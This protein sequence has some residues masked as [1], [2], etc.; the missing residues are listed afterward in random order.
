MAVALLRVGWMI[1]FQ[2]ALSG[3]LVAVRGRMH[4]R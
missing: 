2:G 3:K 1:A 4:G